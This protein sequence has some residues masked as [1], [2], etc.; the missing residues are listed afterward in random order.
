VKL[1]V[2]DFAIAVGAPASWPEIG[3][4]E[5]PTVDLSASPEASIAVRKGYGW[6]KPDAKQPRV[7]E[8][9][10]VCA[11]APAEG[12]GDSI[13]DAVFGSMVQ[14][15]E[16]D[17]QEFTDLKSLDPD[18][19]HAEGDRIVQP[20]HAWANFTHDGEKSDLT[21]AGEDD[22]DG[23]GGKKE[24]KAAATRVQLQGLS[25]VGFKAEAGDAR[26]L[27]A[28][29]V[30]CAD[31][32]AQG[33]KGVCPDV[34]QSIE[35]SGSF[36]TAPKRSWLADLVF[37][38]KKDRTTG[39]LI[40]VGGVVGLVVVGVLLAMLFRKKK[41]DASATPS[42]VHDAAEDEDF[43]A[44]YEAGLA[45]ARADAGSSTSSQGS[46]APMADGNVAATMQASPSSSSP[47]GSPSAST[48]NGSPLHASP[49]PPQGYFDPTTLQP[50]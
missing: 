10:V 40:L 45:A 4:D 7:A 33:D 48:T 5:L 34:V 2:G 27:V 20:F 24:K 32:V 39:I 11:K 47:S 16:K 23:S 37:N 36:T 35:V 46:P 29:T 14:G 44:G 19:I 9:V 6:H 30:A 18:P 3:D 50:R 22:K 43:Q 12:W 21:P 28:C 41:P 1:D 13:R 8:V 26:T 17:A 38:F 25:F 31:L 42:G 49:P 15:I